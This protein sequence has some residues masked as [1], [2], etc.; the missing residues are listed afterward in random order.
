MKGRAAGQERHGAQGRDRTTDTAI[1]SRMLYQLSYLGTSS[2]G[3]LGAAVYSQAGRPCPPRFAVRLRAAR[4]CNWPKA[5]RVR[6]S[7]KGGDGRPHEGTLT[8]RKHG[9]IPNRRLRPP[10][11][12]PGWRRSSTASGSGRHPGS[13]PNRTAGRPRSKAC[14]RSDT[15]LRLPCPSRNRPA[16]QL[17]FNQPKR[18]GNP[19]P[20][21]RVTVSYSGKPTILV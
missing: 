6:L 4:P 13:A 21:S 5:G 12:G 1:F 7:P 9:N 16:A 20:P 11:C 10:A 19:S 3:G 17:A 2:H 15:A 18:T 8:A 14:R